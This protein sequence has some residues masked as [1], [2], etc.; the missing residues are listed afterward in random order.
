MLASVSMITAML[1]R[2]IKFYTV[3][4]QEELYSMELVVA[5][6]GYNWG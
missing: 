3:S 1:L 6:Q 5:G 4:V 2:L